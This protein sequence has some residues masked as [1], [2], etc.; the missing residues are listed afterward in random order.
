MR[1]W[2]PLL[3]TKPAVIFTYRHPLEVAMS[4][5]KRQGFAL[6]RGL[7]LWIQYN[8]AAII[9]SADLCRVY[10]SNN[11]L[12]ADP[13][14]E[15]KRIAAELTSKCHVPAAPKMIDQDVVNNFVDNTLQHNKNKL[16][17]RAEEKPVLETH[18]G[19][20]V[21]KD[22]DSREIKGSAE[23]KLEMKTYL[24]AMKMYCDFESGDAYKDDYEWPAL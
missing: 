12:L 9:N 15:T 20:C 3:N 18:H 16:K 5:Q 13:L 19:N 17:H 24:I 10:S 23:Q 14:N 11:A 8:K 7:R 1:T 22:F 4:L 21:V 2:L 6:W